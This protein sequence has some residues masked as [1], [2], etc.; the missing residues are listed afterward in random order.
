MPRMRI[1]DAS[2]GTA[3]RLQVPPRKASPSQAAESE[4]MDRPATPGQPDIHGKLPSASAQA[5]PA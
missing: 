1:E 5:S 2:K 3:A 4:P